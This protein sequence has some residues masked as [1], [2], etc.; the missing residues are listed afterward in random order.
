M[1]T[2]AGQSVLA[3]DTVAANVETELEKVRQRLRSHGGDLRLLELTPEGEVSLE[4]VGACRGCPALGFTYS[5]VVQPAVAGVAGVA[6]VS[7]GHAHLSPHVAR[8][9]G[10]LA[11][12]P[13]Q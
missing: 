6:E 3:Q 13:K 2:A 11:R 1:T 4:F 12:T 5:A 9:V 8:L 7:C 10:E